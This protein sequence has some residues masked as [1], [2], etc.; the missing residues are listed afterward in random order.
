MKYPV[1]AE[2][3]LAFDSKSPN[4]IKKVCKV[5]DSIMGFLLDEV[6]GSAS[7][8]SPFYCDFFT[9]VKT[10]RERRREE[11]R[12]PRTCI[13]EIYRTA[14]HIVQGDTFVLMLFSIPFILFFKK[15]LHMLQ[16]EQKQKNENAS[17]KQIKQERKDGGN[18]LHL[19]QNSRFEQ[20]LSAGFCLC[21]F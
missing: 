21:F 17:K 16:E 15:N 5:A 3:L 12:Q 2:D 7:V 6:R 1:A 20:L 11:H 14:S 9:G 18:A 19:L 13:L 10:T 8:L 4:A